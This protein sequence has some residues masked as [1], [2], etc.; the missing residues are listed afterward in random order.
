MAGK[1]NGFGRSGISGMPETE[2]GPEK[3]ASPLR[4][5]SAHSSAAVSGVRA[6]EASERLDEMYPQ[7]L[8]ND[9]IN[10]ASPGRFDAEL[11]TPAGFSAR[12]RDALKEL[13]SIH[14]ATGSIKAARA[15]KVLHEDLD[16]KDSLQLLRDL[17]KRG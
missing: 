9:L 17:L 5:Q 14:Q 1:I 15:L 7:G 8:N 12:L 4:T 3:G 2:M 6:T 10:F 13:E 16:R 11:L